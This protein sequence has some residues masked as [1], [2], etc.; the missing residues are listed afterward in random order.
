MRWSLQTKVEDTPINNRQTKRT[1]KYT[2]SQYITVGDIVG[3]ASSMAGAV[4]AVARMVP[5]YKKTFKENGDAISANA[6][7]TV[8][9]IAVPLAGIITG[10]ETYSKV[11][12]KIN[13]LTPIMKMVA[14]GTGIWC[15]P[16]NAADIANIVLGTVTQLLVAAITTIIIK[17]K[18][19]V[20][21][22]EFHLR[23]ITTESSMIITK[24]LKNSNEKIQKTV[25]SNLATSS[26]N[27]SAFSFLS[28]NDSNIT[29]GQAMRFRELLKALEEK[30]GKKAEL[31]GLAEQIAQAMKEGIYPTFGKGW[32]SSTL[33]DGNHLREFR[34]S[35]NNYGI[36]Y[37]DI[38]NGKIVWKDSNKKD[39]SFCCFGKITINGKHIYVAGSSPWILGSNLTN[40]NENTWS[41]KDGYY[42]KDYFAFDSAKDA[43]KKSN[44]FHRL[45][46]SFK[47]TNELNVVKNAFR[48]GA[49]VA[50][51]EVNGDGVWFSTDDGKNWYKAS[52]ID[53][54]I[55]GFFE[56]ERKSDGTPTR[57]VAASYDYEGLYYTEDGFN[58]QHSKIDSRNL[59]YSKFIELKDYKNDKVRANGVPIT[60]T[61]TIKATV[62]IL[63]HIKAKEAEATNT[64]VVDVKMK[65][66]EK[67]DLI[68]RILDYIHKNYNSYN[69][70]SYYLRKFDNA[71]W[72]TLIEDI[73]KGN[74]KMSNAIKGDRIIE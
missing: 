26:L 40:T 65:V 59:D 43:N 55:G 38:E 74:Y 3:A 37:S 48:T 66:D 17:L 56:Y 15:S 11:M 64:T 46:K 23:D 60:S 19:W 63:E 1:T 58:W 31:A 49:F 52:G 50:N 71:F 42:N 8:E 5:K 47:D 34:G 12:N 22:F 36:Q 61:A 41:S 70:D 53:G 35:S 18:D 27:Y 14:R 21:N 67:E 72:T 4:K 10:A 28:D 9:N 32:V 57:L 7:Q 29:T 20:W 6:A 39:G 16:G 54:Y 68:R 73:K 44:N 25:K 2:K 33:L 62:Y 69:N 30:A 24:N 13:T 45:S 51:P